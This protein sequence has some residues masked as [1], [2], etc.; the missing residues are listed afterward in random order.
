MKNNFIIK[1]LQLFNKMDVCV[2]ATSDR[3]LHS[4]PVQS[5]NNATLSTVENKSEESDKLDVKEDQQTTYY[6][7]NS[8]SK[9]SISGTNCEMTRKQKSSGNA[10]GSALKLTEHINSTYGD[11]QQLNRIRR[12]ARQQLVDQDNELKT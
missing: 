6:Y 7:D 3:L 5:F 4:H 11:A 10:T 1:N 8:I 12:E 2:T 9:F